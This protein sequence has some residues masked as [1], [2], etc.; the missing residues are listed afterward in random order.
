MEGIENDRGKL[1]FFFSFFPEPFLPLVLVDFPLSIC[2]PVMPLLGSFILHLLRF[3]FL[4]CG[5][6]FVTAKHSTNE[7]IDLNR[8]YYLSTAPLCSVNCAKV[9]WVP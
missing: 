4:I 7:C 1:K 3:S 6:C 2:F 5:K 9:P 8:V